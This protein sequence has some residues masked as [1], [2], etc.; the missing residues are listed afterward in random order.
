M[1]VELYQKKRIYQILFLY[2]SINGFCRHFNLLNLSTVTKKYRFCTNNR[3]FT[4][5][6][7]VTVDIKIKAQLYLAY[8]AYKKIMGLTI[9]CDRKI[10]FILQF[11]FVYCANIFSF[12][13][14]LSNYNIWIYII[15]LL[16]CRWRI[17]DNLDTNMH[18]SYCNNE[19]I[20]IFSG[21]WIFC[22]QFA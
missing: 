11:A 21:H 5:W 12:R 16:N 20:I 6:K 17:I 3:F 18:I 15:L 2:F 4:T 9:W 7:R 13:A 1:T 14:F 8:H 19:N 10:R 22:E